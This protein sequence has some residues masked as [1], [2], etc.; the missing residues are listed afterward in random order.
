LKYFE[1]AVNF[2]RSSPVSYLVLWRAATTDY[3]VEIEGEVFEVK[4][5]PAGGSVTVAEKSSKAVECEGAVTSHM[6]G[7]VLSMNVS[8]GDTVEEGDKVCVIE[9]MKME[10]AIH[11]SHSGV[12]KEIFVSEGDLVG[13]GEVLM[14]IN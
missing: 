13:T 12:V 8:V 9:A 14:A 2:P 6:Q 7:M 1:A 11:A 4:V 10:N 5:E 3:R